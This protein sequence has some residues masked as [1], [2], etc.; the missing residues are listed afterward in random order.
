MHPYF[1]III[2]DELK[3]KNDNTVLSTLEKE[4]PFVSTNDSKILNQL[5]DVMSVLSKK[6]ALTIFLMATQGI[7]SE[8]DTPSK[9]GLTKKQYYTRLKQLIDLGLVSKLGDSYVQTAFGRLIYQKHIVGL[10]NHIKNSKYLEMVDV[11]KSNPKFNDSDIIEFISKVDPQA[12]IELEESSKKPSIVTSS[13]DEMVN[14]VLEIM[15][16]AQKE[17]ILISRFTNE[18]IINTMIKKSNLG[19]DVKVLA[20]V[21]L[22]QDFF[23]KAGPIKVD[24]KN[25]KERITVVANPY[26]PTPIPRKYGSVPFCVLIVDKKHV[27]IE[28]VDGYNAK[29]FKMAIFLTDNHLANQFYN[30]FTTMWAKANEN[31]PQIA[32][33]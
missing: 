16:F 1:L 18:L 2:R 9:I 27:G 31:P 26:Y 3:V 10:T 11:L 25:K 23:L 24:D 32:T 33:K 7:K 30:L 5:A 6:D 4:E 21:N 13:F 28:I 19:I 15:E 17:I 20:D 29:K 12:K 8:L 14:K 22:I